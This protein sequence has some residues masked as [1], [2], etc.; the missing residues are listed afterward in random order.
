MVPP[1]PSFIINPLHL[2]S[3]ACILQD[4]EVYLSG[5]YLAHRGI[6]EPTK[7]THHVWCA[8]ESIKSLEEVV[9]NLTFYTTLE[10]QTFGL[11]L[12]QLLWLFCAS[13]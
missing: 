11:C 9:M 12:L 2:S 5:I 4:M 7:S 6:A 3:T 13:K 8:K 1:L 10:Q